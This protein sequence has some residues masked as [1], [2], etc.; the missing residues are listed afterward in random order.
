MFGKKRKIPDDKYRVIKLNKKEFLELIQ[1]FFLV[2][3]NVLFDV[4][5]SA[6]IVT[7]FDIDWDTGDFICIAKGEV[8]FKGNLEFADV[9]F[10]KL[11]ANLKD[12][13]P[14]SSSDKSYVELSTEEIENIQNGEATEYTK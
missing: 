10:K 1:E 8:G 3:Q 5:N 12:T 11:L 9:D 2:H 4:P 13:A 7:Q 14:N 6:P